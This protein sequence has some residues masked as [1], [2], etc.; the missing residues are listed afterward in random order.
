[1]GRGPDLRQPA[2]Q[3]AKGVGRIKRRGWPLGRRQ[4]APFPPPAKKD[5]RRGAGGAPSWP[6]N[7]SEAQIRSD[8][9]GRLVF[10]FCAA[11][12]K[13]PK[14][15]KGKGKGAGDGLSGTSWRE[16]ANYL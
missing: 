4:C 11:A 6:K 7:L 3:E 1:M 10:F 13:S 9:E 5:R 12:S 14:K 8:P 15:G 16:I 2:V